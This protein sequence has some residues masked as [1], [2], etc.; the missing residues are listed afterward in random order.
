MKITL[1]LQDLEFYF[2][3]MNSTPDIIIL[4]SSDLPANIP[5]FPV[6]T[7]SGP[8]LGC[9]L[10]IGL[11]KLCIFSSFYVL[12]YILLNYLIYLS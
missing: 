10:H 6:R 3:S 5:R 1:I 7:N 12:R 11:P 4:W 8:N 9:L 2:E